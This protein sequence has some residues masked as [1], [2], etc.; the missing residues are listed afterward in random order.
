METEMIDV[1]CPECDEVI[2]VPIHEFVDVSEDP[3]AK[4]K[5]IQGEYFMNECPGCGDMV[6]VEYPLLYVDP[7]HK[8]NVRMDPEHEEDAL[9]V[10]NSLEVPNPEDV[11]DQSFRL[12]STGLELMEKIL[13]AERGLDDRIV[14]LYKFII[15]DDVKEMWPELEPG[16]LVYSFDETGDYLL[17]WTSQNENEEML[18]VEMDPELYQELQ[19]QAM[20]VVDI[21][22]GEYAEVNQEWI[23]ERFEK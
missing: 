20:G 2:Q 5:I 18:T 13:I 16:D 12:V 15:W 21:A 14:E 8:L 19:M 9:D 7:A 4:E 11:A 6:M 1:R 3:E 22:P 23:G 10:L 17:V